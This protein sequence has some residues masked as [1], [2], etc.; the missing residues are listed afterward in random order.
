MNWVDKCLESFGNEKEF[1][2]ASRQLKEAHMPY[3]AETKKELM[4]HYQVFNIKLG[5]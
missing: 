1:K 2:N 3:I 4:N 5:D